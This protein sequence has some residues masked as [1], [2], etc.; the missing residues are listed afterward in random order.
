VEFGIVQ[1]AQ[2]LARSLVCIDDVNSL[3]LPAEQGVMLT[4][5]FYWDRD[6]ETGAWSQ[7]FLSG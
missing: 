1:G 5:A 3:G 6:D 2:K 4:D 7:R